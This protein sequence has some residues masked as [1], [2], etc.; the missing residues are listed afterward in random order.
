[1]LGRF[2]G[3]D[4]VG[5][6][7]TN[8]HSHNRYAYGNNN[9]YKFVD[10][11]GRVAGLVVY[12]GVAFLATASVIYLHEILQHAIQ[13]NRTDK[14][15]DISSVLTGTSAAATPGGMLP[16]GDD[17]DQNGNSGSKDG[18]GVRQ[19]VKENAEIQPNRH[20]FNVKTDADLQNLYNRATVDGERIATNNPKIQSA[21]RLP[22]GSRIQMRGS[23]NTGGRAID[24]EPTKGKPFR[25]HIEPP[26]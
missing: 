3:V 25:I 21:Y 16:E 12:V 17:G 14:G 15:E 20:S 22:D 5:V 23:S 6:S 1:M 19:L 4:P 26:K 24:V 13:Q 9:P 7:D 2:M 18:Q 8:I 10:P 11:D